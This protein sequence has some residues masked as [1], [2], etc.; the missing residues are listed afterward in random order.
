MRHLLA[1]FLCMQD[2][3]DAALEQF[4]LVDGYVRTI[5]WMWHADP[6]Q[7]YCQLRDITVANAKAITP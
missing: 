2:R 7:R 6:A 4:R 1:Y 5:P 3:D